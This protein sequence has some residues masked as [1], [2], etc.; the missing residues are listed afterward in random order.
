MNQNETTYRCRPWRPGTRLRDIY[1]EAGEAYPEHI[2]FVQV[3]CFW[4]ARLHDAEFISKNLGWKTHECNY[5]KQLSVGTSVENNNFESSLKRLNKG[6]VL[7]AQ[8]DNEDSKITRAI[9]YVCTP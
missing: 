1:Q 7:V 8:I 5:E 6:Y 4:E 9:I 3:G 2:V